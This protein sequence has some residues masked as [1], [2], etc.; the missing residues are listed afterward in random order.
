MQP[1]DEELLHFDTSALE[2]WSEE[3]AGA[4]LNGA[5]GALYRNHLHIALLLDRWAEAERGRTDT[6]AGYRA[7]Y[8]QALEDM[9]AFLRQAYYLPEDQEEDQYLDRD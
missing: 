5:H 8:A 1:R 3:R 9:A 2:D 6:G 7:G 4:A